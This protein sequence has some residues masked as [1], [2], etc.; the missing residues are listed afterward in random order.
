MAK[1]ISYTLSADIAKEVISAFSK[2]EY[3]EI[4]F[5]YN[6]FKSAIAQEVVCETILPID[7][8]QRA[9]SDED[10]IYSDDM[11]LNQH[12]SKSSMIY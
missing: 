4:R 1:D 6:E 10:S 2:G 7:V 11:I 8:T 9:L 12:L 5:V 3:D